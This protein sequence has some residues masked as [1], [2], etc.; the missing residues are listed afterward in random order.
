MKKNSL[1]ILKQA[2]HAYLTQTFSDVK[3]LLP[4]ITFE[5][6]TDENKKDFG[7]ISTNAALILAKALKKNPREIAQTI[8]KDFVHEFIQKS[9]I[10][11]PGFINFFL[12][13][14]CIDELAQ[15]LFEHHTNFFSETSESKKRYCIEFVS[16]NPTGPLHFG[17]GRGSIIGDVLGNV[18]K[19]L[20]NDVIKEY[21]INDA[22]SQIIKL[23]ISLKI[24]CQQAL[25]Y[26]AVL[27]EDGYQG[28]YLKAVA[29]SYKSFDYKTEFN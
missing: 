19:F 15:T 13:Q 8:T 18:L 5:L 16:A 1:D 2:F 27:P 6:N 10:A 17:H 7:D 21:Y 22:G 14:A 11:G 4:S 23:G 20:G 9:E 26:D 24:R 3:S 29:Q 28:D 25:G 12:T